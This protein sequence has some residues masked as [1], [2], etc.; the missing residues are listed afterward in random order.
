MNRS[1]VVLLLFGDTKHLALYSCYIP[2][3]ESESVKEAIRDTNEKKTHEK[4]RRNKNQGLEQKREKIYSGDP[5]MA[6]S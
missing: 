6:L 2:M 4:K 3:R 5:S 1:P